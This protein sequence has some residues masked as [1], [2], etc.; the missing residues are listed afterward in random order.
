[1][2]TDARCRICN[3]P[4]DLAEFLRVTST[5]DPQASFYCC[6]PGLTPGGEIVCFGRIGPASLFR[7]ELALPEPRPVATPADLRA[8][9]G[10]QRTSPAT[11]PR[12]A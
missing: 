10:S 1:M 2:T 9:R 8:W 11:S 4:G 3:R 5:R 6:R 7:I 12:P